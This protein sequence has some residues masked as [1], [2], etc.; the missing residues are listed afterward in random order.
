MCFVQAFLPTVDCPELEPGL[1]VKACGTVTGVSLVDC[2]GI[3]DWGVDY[4]GIA[5]AGL[6]RVACSFTCLPVVLP[7]FLL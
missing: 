3:S 5:V 6:A 2:E 4:A 7:Y 1:F